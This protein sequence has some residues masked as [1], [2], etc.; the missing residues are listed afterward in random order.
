MRSHAQTLN[1]LARGCL[2]WPVANFLLRQCCAPLRS[3]RS[4]HR[5]RTAY[6]HYCSRAGAPH[7]TFCTKS[8]APQTKRLGDGGFPLNVASLAVPSNALHQRIHPL[9]TGRPL[10]PN[11]AAPR[12]EGRYDDQPQCRGLVIHGKMYV[13]PACGVDISDGMSPCDEHR[14]R[15]LCARLRSVHSW[16][17]SGPL[18]AAR[19]RNW[20]P[21][22]AP[23]SDDQL[24]ASRDKHCNAIAITGTRSWNFL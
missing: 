20:R 10:N 14:S 19:L 9:P 22:T 4:P 6:G 23:P 16:L 13:V 2:V 1:P 18:P 15:H 12:D 7:P 5:F 8:Q 21:T 17:T 3:S 11:C 24:H